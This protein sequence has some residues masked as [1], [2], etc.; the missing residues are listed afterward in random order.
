ML[1]YGFPLPV[2]VND[3][4]SDD[5]MGLIVRNARFV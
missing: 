1:L 3:R 5:Q 4:A 2:S